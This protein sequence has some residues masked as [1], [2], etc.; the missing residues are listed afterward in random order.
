M[1][2]ALVVAIMVSAS[3]IGTETVRLRAAVA[4]ERKALDGAHAVEALA[5][6]TID[7]VGRQTASALDTKHET[8]ALDRERQKER[9]QA[10]TALIRIER[11]MDATNQALTSIKAIQIQIARYSA[12]RDACIRGL[13]RATTA[14]QAGN[15]SAATAAL[16][17]ADQPCAAALAAATG[18]RFPYDFPDPSV[19]TVGSR[20]YAYSTNSGTGNMQVLVSRDLVQWSIVGDGLAGLPGWAARGAT[21]APAVFAR[22]AGF[23][24]YY[25]AR[26]IASGRQCIS[27]AVSASPAGPFVDSSTAPLVCQAGGSIDPS[28]LVDESGTAWL[29]W[30]SEATITE[31]PTIWSQPLSTDGLTLAGVPTPMLTPGQRWEGGVVEAPS[32]IR[33]AGRDYLFYS[34]NR[35]T[36]AA[37]AE[38]VAVCDGPAG[39]CRRIESGPV[40]TSEGR[41]A[42][43][44]GGAAFVTPTGEVWLAFHA[45]TD[46]DVGYPNSRTLHFATVRIVGGVPIVSPQ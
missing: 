23:I 2:G 27:V 40:L 1:V 20:V 21:W 17:A 39:P 35:W 34:G 4:R 42:G 43:P 18:A 30:K 28:P 44:G 9:S 26:E 33:I 3:V 46:P 38:G 12:Q 41:L 10:N 8:L 24:A 37:Y 22:G 36:T 6:H 13:R 16:R 11:G 32:M 5:Q 29:L 31:P 45:F 7:D 15:P 25:T 19:L 14:L